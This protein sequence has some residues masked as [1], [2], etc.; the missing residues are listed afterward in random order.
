MIEQCGATQC[1]Q[2]YRGMLTTQMHVRELGDAAEVHLLS[3]W[4]SLHDHPTEDRTGLCTGGS[5]QEMGGGL[6][7]FFANK[8]CG[9]G[10][11]QK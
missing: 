11:Q 3:T 10:I 4:A 5:G 2:Y 6:G 1:L 8:I 7:R 9:P